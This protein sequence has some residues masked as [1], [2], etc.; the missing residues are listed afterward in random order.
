MDDRTPIREIS[1]EEQLIELVLRSSIEKDAK[2]TFNDA[3]NS[4]GPRHSLRGRS[5]SS[6]GPAGDRGLDFIDR[7]EVFK[8]ITGFY[9]YSRNNREVSVLETFDLLYYS[10]LTQ[11]LLAII[12]GSAEHICLSQVRMIREVSVLLAASGSGMDLAVLQSLTLDTW[13]ALL[14]FG[15]TCAHNTITNQYNKPSTL[16]NFMVEVSHLKPES[17][18]PGDQSNVVVFHV[19][20]VSHRS[21]A[22]AH[23]GIMSTMMS[24]MSPN[25][26]Q[27]NGQDPVKRQWLMLVFLTVTWAILAD[28]YY[29]GAR[30][31]LL[32]PRTENGATETR[33]S[34]EQ[35][36]MWNALVDGVKDVVD[37]NNLM[38]V[39][40][41]SAAVN[42]SRNTNAVAKELAMTLQKMGG[43]QRL[44]DYVDSEKAN[45]VISRCSGEQVWVGMQY[46]EDD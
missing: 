28:I 43:F 31:A 33:L 24:L 45:C 7:P 40:W 3:S 38:R 42:T 35:S 25:S 17:L 34:V 32:W 10:S 36:K 6:S 18:A 37:K 5:T 41:S 2:T 26:Q 13:T 19:Y 12:Y 29:P 23:D 22:T 8:S 30:K 11:C 46:D 4:S 39:L 21:L 9:S 14:R 16:N 27:L 15:L 44:V 1:K 20:T